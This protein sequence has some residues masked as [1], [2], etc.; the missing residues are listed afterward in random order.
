ML[1]PVERVR[2]FKS[3]TTK[4]SQ[5]QTLTLC[6][7]NPVIRSHSFIVKQFRRYLLVSDR[8]ERIAGDEVQLDVV[9]WN[10]LPGISNPADYDGWIMNASV[11][12]ARPKPKVFSTDE[13]NVLFH[14]TAFGPVLLGG[15]R[16]YVVGDFTTA[17]FTPASKRWGRGRSVT[18]TAI[19]ARAERLRAISRAAG[20]REGLST[21]RLS[22]SGAAGRVPF[23]DLYKYLD[24]VTTWQYSLVVSGEHKAVENVDQLAT[25]NF[26]TCAAAVFKIAGGW[27]VILPSLGGTPERDEKYVLEHF[28]AFGSATS[29]PKWATNF[30]L[31]AQREIE[32]S[33]ADY[34]Q[35]A[36]ELIE[37]AG[38]EKDRICEL[39]RWKR[40]LYDDGLSLENIVGEALTAFGAVSVETPKGRA[41][42]RM[43]V[44][45][46]G[47]FVL[48]VKGTRGDQFSR[49]HLRQLTEWMDDAVSSDL[50]E[51]KGAFVG[52]AAR[53]KAPTDRS[54]MFDEN[55][56]QYAKLK[57]MVLLRS[58]DLYWMVVLELLGRLDKQMFWSELFA[59]IGYFNAAK[60]VDTVPPEFRL[61][62][63]P[64]LAPGDTK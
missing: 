10:N 20:N 52:N 28:F 27:I 33:R 13:L 36:R 6:L 37:E 56:L 18:G 16:I 59:T 25:T 32:Q 51:V 11:L 19:T 63:S 21:D 41:D 23:Q 31:P 42:H 17:F 58:M 30:V 7:A 2:T 24:E 50:A 57:R 38:H 62:A 53:D 48:E 3:L 29:A 26:G 47:S 35:R 55:S 22:E 40:L 15:G 43:I 12:K 54:G 46:H 14:R 60:Y 8:E 5:S 4:V 1:D 61:D 9:S 45:E 64:T 39:E 34:V 49:R 44:A